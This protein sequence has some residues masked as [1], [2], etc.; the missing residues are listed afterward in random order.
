MPRSAADK[1]EIRRADSGSF[2]PKA[3]SFE[4]QE[5]P[6]FKSKAKDQRK[7]TNVPVQSARQAEFSLAQPFCSI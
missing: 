1:L 4:I 5:E 2:S 6:V 7:K 3:A